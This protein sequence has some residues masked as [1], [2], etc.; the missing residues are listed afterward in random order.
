M[1]DSRPDTYEHIHEV[2]R[3][4][5]RLSAALAQRALYHDQSKLQ[6]PELSMFNEFRSKLDE[7]EH[8]SPEYKVHLEEMGAALEHHYRVNRHH[9]EHFANGIHGMNL[10]DLMELVCDWV[11]AAG[12]KGESPVPYIEGA[13][14]ERFGYGEEIERLLVKTSNL[15][16]PEVAHD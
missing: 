16:L 11:A 6:E 13:A 8:E 4:L 2:Q 7:V 14:K 12:R 3:G 10:L 1:S 5:L 15:L 9:P